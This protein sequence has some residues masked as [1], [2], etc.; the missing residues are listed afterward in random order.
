LAQNLSCALRWISD[1][2][3]GPRL[4]WFQDVFSRSSRRYGEDHETSSPVCLLLFAPDR[5]LG[6]DSTDEDDRKDRSSTGTAAHH[7]ARYAPTGVRAPSAAGAAECW[8][9]PTSTARSHSTSQ[10]AMRY[11]HVAQDRD[12]LIAAKLPG[13]FSLRFVPPIPRSPTSPTAGSCKPR[14]P[15]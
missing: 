3:A 2:W 12:A 1:V 7:Q 14:Q 9:V 15:T 13:G 4:T 11:Q 5:R 10:A 8:P 6:S